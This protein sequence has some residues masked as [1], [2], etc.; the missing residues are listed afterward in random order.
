MES[1]QLHC[2][3][4]H[5]TDANA[6]EQGINR[7]ELIHLLFLWSLFFLCQVLVVSSGVPTKEYNS[8]H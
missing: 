7:P 3:P 5:D 6:R 8:V 2:S 1:R 4:S